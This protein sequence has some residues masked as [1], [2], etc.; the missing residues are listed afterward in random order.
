MAQRDV[1]A[2]SLEHC[3]GDFECFITRMGRFHLI[4]GNGVR[5][6]HKAVLN[7]FSVF[8]RISEC[9]MIPS[10]PPC[11]SGADSSRIWFLTN[12]DRGLAES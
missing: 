4:S 10:A 8:S 11:P 5:C 2:G 1:S 6:A 7:G 12:S 3:S 9:A